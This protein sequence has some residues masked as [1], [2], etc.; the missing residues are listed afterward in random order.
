MTTLTFLNYLIPVMLAPV[1][2]F[3]QQDSQSPPPPPRELPDRGYGPTKTNQQ[4]GPEIRR[5]GGRWVIDL[6]RPMEAALRRYNRRFE[7]WDEKTFPTSR[8][9]DAA[10]SSDAGTRY[11]NSTRQ[12]PWGVIGDFNGDGIPDAAVSGND[13]KEMLVLLVL[14]QNGDRYKIVSLDSEPYSPDSR[15]RMSA[16]HLS[17][18]YPGKYYT[19]SSRRGTGRK[20]TDK[21][22][23]IS[24]TNKKAVELKLPGISL[25]GGYRSSVGNTVFQIVDDKIVQLFDLEP[26]SPARNSR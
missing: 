6:P 2:N 5:S 26:I 7:I 4:S 3:A 25:S 20:K 10:R 18:V 21:R 22:G 19:T 9:S 23:Q 8:N 17:Y 11:L 15:T 13:D 16:P 24:N 14:S 1:M 12:I